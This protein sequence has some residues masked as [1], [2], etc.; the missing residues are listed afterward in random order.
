[1]KKNIQI[2]IFLLLNIFLSPIITVFLICLYWGGLIM[3]EEPYKTNVIFLW[4]IFSIFLLRVLLFPFFYRINKDN[5]LCEYFV[6]IKND[7]NFAAKILIVSFLID[8][9]SVSF[10]NII[11]AI[12]ENIN[13]NLTDFLTMF[14]FPYIFGG[15]G[16]LFAYLSLLFYIRITE[17]KFRQWGFFNV[18]ICLLFLI[19]LLP[20]T[21][22]LLDA[23]I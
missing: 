15:Y 20:I 5:F 1:M 11:L 10:F 16:L 21:I 8:F 2:I 4:I 3:M 14:L 13:L 6:K 23:V 22:V 17:E 9:M 7:K 18:I 19:M 12:S